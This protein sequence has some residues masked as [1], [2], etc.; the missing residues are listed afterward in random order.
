MNNYCAD[1]NYI[2]SFYPTVAAGGLS[3]LVIIF[4]WTPFTEH[5]NAVRDW[6][7]GTGN[8]EYFCPESRL[9]DELENSYQFLYV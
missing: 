6:H 8:Y 7:N 5:Y 9:D 2:W 4:S 3:L 1:K